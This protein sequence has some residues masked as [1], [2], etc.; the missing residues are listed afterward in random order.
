MRRRTWKL[1]IDTLQGNKIPREFHIIHI[2][3]HDLL[4]MR[5]LCKT[6]RLYCPGELLKVKRHY[7]SSSTET[8]K[9]A[10]HKSATLKKWLLVGMDVSNIRGLAITRCPGI[11]MLFI[12]GGP[13]QT[14]TLG[15]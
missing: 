14:S 15:Y 3:V 11:T 8:L 7:V 10:L 9:N 4:E 2:R 13:R 1:I 12:V 6:L 5:T